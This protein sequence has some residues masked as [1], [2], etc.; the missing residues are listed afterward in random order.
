MPKINS[1]KSPPPNPRVGSTALENTSY[2]HRGMHTIVVH[3]AAVIGAVLVGGF[4]GLLAWG[5][6]RHHGATLHVV[7]L[8]ATA[9]TAAVASWRATLRQGLS[10]R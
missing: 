1:M 3:L 2:T 9:L 8:A 4:I 5:Q 7:E 10:R 6:Y